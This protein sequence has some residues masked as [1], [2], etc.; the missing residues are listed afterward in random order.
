MVCCGELLQAKPA[1][2]EF[3]RPD[4]PDLRSWR[5]V[6]YLAG[7]GADTHEVQLV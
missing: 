5:N 1:G 6:C 7:I 3:A 2:Y 4:A